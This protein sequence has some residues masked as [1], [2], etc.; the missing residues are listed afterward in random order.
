MYTPRHFENATPWQELLPQH[1]FG[2]LVTQDGDDLCTT[3]LPYLVSEDGRALRMHMARANPHWKTIERQPRCRF[4]IQG[5]HAYISPSWYETPASVPTWNYEAIHVEGPATLSL[6]EEA[7]W[8]L[9]TDMSQHF[10]EPD[11]GWRADQLTERFRK[12]LLRSI[13]GIELKLEQVSA[14]QKLSQ[15]RSSAERTRIAAELE[16][17]G[18]AALATSIRNLPKT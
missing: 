7:L 1:T 5:A 14:K 2:L 9:V 13:V 15:N 4:I 11:S 17:R 8:S 3:H 12:P 16:E 18:E 10:E 6:D